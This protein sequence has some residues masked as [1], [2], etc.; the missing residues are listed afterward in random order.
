[1][2][3]T[4]FLTD[5][6]TPRET[7]RDNQIRLCSFSESRARRRFDTADTPRRQH[8]IGALA[9]IQGCLGWGVAH[10]WIL[11]RTRESYVIWP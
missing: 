2:F 4:L 9:R 10:S 7:K 11:R 3:P 8:R 1:M 6:Q 5:N